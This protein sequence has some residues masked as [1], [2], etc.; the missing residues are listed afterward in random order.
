MKNI[1]LLENNHYDYL[2]NKLL[3]LL[4]L[5]YVWKQFAIATF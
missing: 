4:L 3:E 1:G 5:F 2:E